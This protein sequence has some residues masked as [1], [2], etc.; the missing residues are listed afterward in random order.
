[1]P[2]IPEIQDEINDS[3]IRFITVCTK[4]D[5]S[6]KAFLDENDLGPAGIHTLPVSAYGR[7]YDVRSTPKVFV[8]DSDNKIASKGIGFGQIAEVIKALKNEGDGSATTTAN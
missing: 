6:C 1:M 2:T 5:E 4:A 3:S 7:L 8:I